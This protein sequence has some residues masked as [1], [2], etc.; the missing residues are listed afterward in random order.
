M[1]AHRAG[2]ERIILSKRN[3]KDL[4]DVPEEVKAALRF[5]FVE[6]ASEVLKL[7]LGL[8]TSHPADNEISPHTG[9]SQGSNPSQQ[10][11]VNGLL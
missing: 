8:V 1:A 3:E 9:E 11:G 6:N 7:A 2:I 5:E 10:L 4:R